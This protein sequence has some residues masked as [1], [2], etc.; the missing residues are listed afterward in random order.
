MLKVNSSV[1]GETEEMLMLQRRQL[2][3]ISDKLEAVRRTLLNDGNTFQRE[4]DAIS[5]RRA[6]L[7]NRIEQLQ[8]L[9]RTADSLASM[10]AR[11]EM[12]L[13]N[14]RIAA[15][16]GASDLPAP[17]ETGSYLDP[18]SIELTYSNIIIP[19]LGGE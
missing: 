12:E 7:E 10:Y 6:D 16:T 2:I 11:C 19:L 13:A 3:E 14:V 5:R 18:G 9:A 1:L 15:G 8:A 17:S 4:A